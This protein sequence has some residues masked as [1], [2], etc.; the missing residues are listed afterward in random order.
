MKRA[1][2]HPATKLDAPLSLFCFFARF[3]FVLTLLLFLESGNWAVPSVRDVGVH[4]SR[5]T[6]KKK[7]EN[8]EMGV[9]L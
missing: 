4:C 1:A 9:Y 3:C 7:G 2:I 8:E 5:H 6:R